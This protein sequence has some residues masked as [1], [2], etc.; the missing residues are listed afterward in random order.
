MK[1]YPVDERDSS[2]EDHHPKFRIYIQNVYRPGYGSSTATYD[3]EDCDILEAIEWAKAHTGEGETYSVTLVHDELQPS[4]PDRQPETQRGLVWLL[5]ADVNGLNTPTFRLTV[6]AGSS[7][8]EHEESLIADD[9]SD[10]SQTIIVD[11]EM[12]AISTR[13]DGHIDHRWLSGIAP[14]YGFMARPNRPDVVPT[15]EQTKA[16]IRDFMSNVNPETGYLD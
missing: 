10:R 9:A 6:R 4:G 16:A 2:W 14:G 5:G 11:G 8:D 15:L 7:P 1:A 3:L 12:W 13:G